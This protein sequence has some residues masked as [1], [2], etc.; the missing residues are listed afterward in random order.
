MAA[1]LAT[2]LNSTEAK[3]TWDSNNFHRGGPISRFELKISYQR[4]GNMHTVLVPA[5]GSN[6]VAINLERISEEQVRQV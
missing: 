4:T 3:I 2:F 5:N 1:P 6:Q